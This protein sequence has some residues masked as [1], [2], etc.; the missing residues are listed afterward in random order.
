[1]IPY[2]VKL[3]RHRNFSEDN[4]FPSEVIKTW[5]NENEKSM[6]NIA[7]IDEDSPL[8]SYQHKPTFNFSNF[9]L[10]LLVNSWIIATWSQILSVL[11]AP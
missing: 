10:G 3:K 11:N 8:M 6:K 9:N 7:Y 1:M 5:I 4:Q 2:Q